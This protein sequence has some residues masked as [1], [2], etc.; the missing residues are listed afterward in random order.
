MSET[1]THISGH[2]LRTPRAA[3]L[4][5]IVFAL[6]FATSIVL[7]RISIPADP[8]DGGAWLGEYSKNVSFAL[9]LV[10]LSG[11]AFLW[12]MGVIRDRLGHLEDQF[13][14]TV[15]FGSG[16]L[17]LA[18]AFI[19]AAIAGGILFTYSLIPDKIVETG[20]YTFSRALMNGIIN[21]YG[22]RMAGVFMF[23]LAT[24]WMRTQILHRYLVYMTY[25]LALVLLFSINLSL[26]ATLIFPIW[27]FVISIN[28]LIT[29]LRLRPV[30]PED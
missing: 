6:L 11:I 7:L 19:A 9:T 15:F 29:N 21:I 20:V 18:M 26:W 24:I 1:N 10:P 23:S 3:A 12:F 14:S 2:R 8:T 4:A 16:I 13:F 17:F 28:I 5:G 27:V 22:I 25:T 30:I